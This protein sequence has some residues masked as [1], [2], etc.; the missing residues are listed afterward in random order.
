MKLKM[1][2]DEIEAIGG[3]ELAAEM[4]CISADHLGAASD[5]GIIAMKDA[6]WCQCFC[7]PRCFL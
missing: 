3:A 7:Q 2:A 5:A 4:A 1:H 6:G